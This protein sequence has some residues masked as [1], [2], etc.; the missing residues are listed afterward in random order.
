MDELD[1]IIFESLK[2]CKVVVH[3]QFKKTLQ[4]WQ[5]NLS[6]TL[7]LEFLLKVNIF[8]STQVVTVEKNFSLSYT[9]ALINLLL[10]LENPCLVCF[11]LCK[12]KILSNS[13][14]SVQINSF[15]STKKLSGIS[16]TE[17]KKLL[18]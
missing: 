8:L 15:Q 13:R 3:F 6:D 12:W 7:I 2:H 4:I 11:F 1:V 18:S 17:T 9:N 5:N 16:Y 14:N 10:T